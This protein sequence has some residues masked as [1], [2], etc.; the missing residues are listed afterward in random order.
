MWPRFN[1]SRDPDPRVTWPRFISSRGTWE[2]SFKALVELWS[3]FLKCGRG[4]EILSYGFNLICTECVGLFLNVTFFTQLEKRIPN[5]AKKNKRNPS[6]IL[7][8]MDQLVELSLYNSYLF[9]DPIRLM[10]QTCLHS[11]LKNTLLFQCNHPTIPLSPR[12]WS[13]HCGLEQTRIET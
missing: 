1:S 3:L 11:S 4:M 6:R 12:W 9:N 10:I 8:D 2:F 13:A 5:S 7:D